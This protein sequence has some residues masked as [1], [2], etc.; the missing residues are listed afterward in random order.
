MAARPNWTGPL[1]LA[2]F[3]IPAEIHLA[4]DNRADDAL[5]QFYESSKPKRKGRISIDCLHNQCGSTAIMPYGASERP[6]APMAAPI[7]WSEVGTIRGDAHFML[8]DCAELIELRSEALLK[9]WGVA[10]MPL[11]GN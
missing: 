9:R 2:V 3:S 4:T 11:P 5:G 8:N 1:R 6:G 10:D 7:A